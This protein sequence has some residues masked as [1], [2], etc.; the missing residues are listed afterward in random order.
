MSRV[1]YCVD[2]MSFVPADHRARF[3]WHTVVRLEK[4]EEEA[5]RCVKKY[6]SYGYRFEHAVARC[7]A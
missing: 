6:I 4:C 1:Y 5:C 3:R 7:F 2:C